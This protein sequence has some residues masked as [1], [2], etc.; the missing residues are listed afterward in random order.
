M[1]SLCSG[2]VSTECINFSMQRESWVMSTKWSFVYRVH[3]I[4][5]QT[6]LVSHIC[7]NKWFLQ[8]Q[9]M[10]SQCMDIS[11]ECESWIIFTKWSHA[12]KVKSC[13][14]SAVIFTEWMDFSKRRDSWVI[15]AKRS[16]VYRV[17]SCFHSVWTLHLSASHDL[18]GVATVSRIDK[19]IGLF[20]KPYKRDII[21]QKRPL[22]LSILFTWVRVNT[23]NYKVKS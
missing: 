8:T 5:K 14:Q 22:I 13:L 17:E 3:G 23:H 1:T 21:L 19:I 12:C 15:C 11:F 6:W 18:Y 20:C 16:H 4:F 7:Q 10:F 2:V 9:I